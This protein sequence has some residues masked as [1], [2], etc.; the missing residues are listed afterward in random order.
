M[1]PHRT[2]V[3]NLKEDVFAEVVGMHVGMQNKMKQLGHSVCA[4]R[5]LVVHFAPVMYEE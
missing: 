5:E 4:E 1:V 3:Y 2:N